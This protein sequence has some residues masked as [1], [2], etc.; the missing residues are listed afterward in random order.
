MS[1]RQ[2]V[3]RAAVFSVAAAAMLTAIK[4]V[5][6]IATNSIGIV[7]E[8]LH[9]GLDLLAA[10][11]TL[12]AVKKAAVIADGEHHYGHGK[13]ENFAALAETIILW[14]TAGWIIYEAT[15]RIVEGTVIEA[16][17]T[18]IAV[19]ITSIVID[20]ER[21]R[22]LMK[23]ARTHGSQALEADALHFSTDMLSSVVVLC[24]LGL[25]AVGFPIGDSLGALGVSVVILLVSYRLA[26]RSYDY[27]TDRAP[28]GVREKIR[29]VCADI[30]SVVDCSRIR[31][32]MAGPKLFV[33]II[34]TVESNT[35]LERAHA[36]ADMVEARVSALAAHEADVIVHVEPTNATVAHGRGSNLYERVESV[37]R[38]HPSKVNMHNVRMRTMSDGVYLVADLEMSSELTL[39]RAH[40]VSEVLEAAL[41]REIPELRSVVF[42]LES[43]EYVTS[44]EVVTASTERIVE[45]VRAVVDEVKGAD[46]CRDVIVTKDRHGFAVCLTCEVDGNTSLADSHELAEE[47]ERRVKQGIP[48]VLSVTVHLEPSQSRP[49]P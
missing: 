3:R 19:M 20:Y 25:V 14:V 24:G 8:A 47:I 43:D 31:T 41:K 30:P 9:S 6:G 21:S 5:V 12:V 35:G 42:H 32:R 45:Y 36:I 10:A 27:L 11:I 18:G 13:I 16:S 22:M 34:V 26:R 37:V 29:E 7:S 2:E 1:A 28:D 23:T 46:N 44:A 48:E 17:V 49:I 4:L 40:S 39:E 38:R 15:R 33:D